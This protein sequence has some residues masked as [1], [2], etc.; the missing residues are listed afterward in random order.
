MNYKILGISSKLILV[1]IFSMISISA[2][3]IWIKIV[4][5]IVLLLISF[6]ID[7]ILDKKQEQRLHNDYTFLNG[8]KTGELVRIQMKKGNQIGPAV[9]LMNHYKLG[10]LSVTLAPFYNDPVR[11]HELGKT[12]EVK[13]RKIDSIEFIDW[14]LAE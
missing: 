10:S 12:K 7:N 8:L 4:F 6:K 1:V 11:F 3:S 5:S 2:Q 9:F 14:E 13:L